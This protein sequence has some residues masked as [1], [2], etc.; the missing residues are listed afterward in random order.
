MHDLLLEKVVSSNALKI[1]SVVKGLSTM[2]IN[3]L[4]APVVT[5]YNV[6]L[7]WLAKIT[8]ACSSLEPLGFVNSRLRHRPSDS[9]TLSYAQSNQFLTSNLQLVFMG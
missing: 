2:R 4:I 5:F 6:N 3:F 7:N 8:H 9:R 1:L